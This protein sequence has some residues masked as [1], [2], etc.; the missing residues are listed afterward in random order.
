[1]VLL[2]K[3]RFKP[4][5]PANVTVEDLVNH[6][7]YCTEYLSIFYKHLVEL[8]GLQI[9]ILFSNPKLKFLSNFFQKVCMGAGTESPQFLFRYSPLLPILR[10]EIAE[11]FPGIQ[12]ACTFPVCTGFLRISDPF[13]E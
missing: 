8:G 3:E 5:F 2:C 4:T 12:K 9:A 6:A 11:Q 13:T 1:M 7:V 10:R